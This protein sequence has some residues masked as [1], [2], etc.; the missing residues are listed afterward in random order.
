MLLVL[1]THYHPSVAPIHHTKLQQP[2]PSSSYYHESSSYRT[3]HTSH[4]GRITQTNW[5]NHRACIPLMGWCVRVWST[6]VCLAQLVRLSVCLHACNLPVCMSVCLSACLC[7]SVCLSV[8][9]NFPAC[10]SVCRCLLSPSVS[11]CLPVSIR[12]LSVGVCHVH[13]SLLVCQ[14][15]CLSVST[16]SVCLSWST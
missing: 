14:V 9:V 16:M 8:S 1:I 3:H 11:P 12:L 4:C 7:L 5:Y 13:L 15:A 10:M 2:P 6:S